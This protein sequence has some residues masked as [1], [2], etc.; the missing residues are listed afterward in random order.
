M[1]ARM[2]VFAALSA[3]VAAVV[4]VMGLPVGKPDAQQVAL[5]ATG[6]PLAPQSTI[7][8]PVLE[9]TDPDPFDACRDIPVDVINSLG[10]GFTPP[11][12][13]EGLRCHFDAG[14]YQMAVEPFVWRTY[15]DTLPTDAVET[16]IGGHRAASYWVMKPTDWNNRWWFS[17]MITFRTSYGV[18]QQS[19]F[20]SPIHSP[21]APDCM[22]E[23]MLRAQQL[24]PYYKF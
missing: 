14:N 20:F 5:R 12:P 21:N 17:C 8:S 9:L 1:V 4:L 23:N 18:I 3:L 2:R 16:T 7:K 6:M 15:E 13:E 24:V 10:L 19:L 11:E 22:Q